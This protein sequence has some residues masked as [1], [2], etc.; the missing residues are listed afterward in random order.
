MLKCTKNHSVYKQYKIYMGNLTI[1]YLI[2]LLV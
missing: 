2:L 1:R